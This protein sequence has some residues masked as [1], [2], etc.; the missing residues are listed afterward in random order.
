MLVDK[1]YISEWFENSIQKNQL[2]LGDNFQKFCKKLNQT[3]DIPISY[4][5]DILSGN[6]SINDCDN[7]I[8]YCLVEEIKPT[9]INKWFLLD[10]SK[11][12]KKEKYK[13]K[14]KTKYP[15]RIEAI[16][17]A[18]N[19]WITG[20]TFKFLIDLQ[21]DNILNYNK[22]TQRVLE[23]VVDHEQY[24]Y[25]IS[26]N[27]KSIAEIKESYNN[28]FYIPNT[29]TLNIPEDVRLRYEDGTLIIPKLNHVDILDGYHRFS[30]AYENYLIDNNFDYP[31][32]LR[33][34]QFDESRSRQFIY[35]EDQKTKMKK[36]D[37]DSYNQNNPGNILTKKIN[38]DMTFNLHGQISNTGLI[39]FSHFA[40]A[41]NV[42]FFKS[43]SS[44]LK[45]IIDNKKIIIE[46]MN[47]L[48]EEEPDIFFSQEYSYGK[49]YIILYLL[50]NY[51]SSNLLQ[52]TLKCLKA[53]KDIE[54][55]TSKNKAKNIIEEMR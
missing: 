3:H 21:Q 38:E 10:E 17:I 40:K 41:V 42:L 16:Q 20:T 13:K 36:I 15:L 25:R 55:Y 2:S 6:I 54:T 51:G 11:K 29:I 24:V 4:T 8:I 52:E 37:S 19:Q 7:F 18:E 32:E 47:L 1:E 34:V 31:T 26:R 49:I 43:K 44:S 9:L 14:K 33:I 35:Q 45:N 27:K 46:G 30:A 22:A 5:S 39:Q 23:K 50:K 53:E 12:F 48:S 28:K